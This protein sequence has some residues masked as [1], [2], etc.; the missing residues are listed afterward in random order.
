LYLSDYK[1]SLAVNS[2]LTFRFEKY[3]LKQQWWIN[4]KIDI[5]WDGAYEWYEAVIESINGDEAVVRYNDQSTETVKLSQQIFY[6]TMDRVKK[7]S[8]KT[9]NTFENV[10]TPNLPPAL[11]IPDRVP[12]SPTRP[13]SNPAACEKKDVE[14]KEEP[15]ELQTIPVM[16][17]PKSFT[18]SHEARARQVLMSNT[19]EELQFEP[20][21][22]IPIEDAIEL[23]RDYLSQGIVIE[24]EDRQIYDGKTNV[25]CKITCLPCKEKNEESVY[26]AQGLLTIRNSGLSLKNHCFPTPS[27]T[28]KQHAE[29]LKEWKQNGEPGLSERKIILSNQ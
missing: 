28:F 10:K 6:F 17:N 27:V 7:A 18:L 3:D 9:T 5:K 1:E 29:N 14:V 25:A 2:E 19:G 4:K 13:R 16:Q 20:K 26:F 23:Q 12:G 15:E 22:Y 21:H 8:D 11:L 24:E